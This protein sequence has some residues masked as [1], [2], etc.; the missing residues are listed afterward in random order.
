MITSFARTLILYFCI[1]FC[2]RIMG[3]R[4]LGEL[5][6]SEL[7]TSILISDLAAVPM[8][9][10]G[11]PLLQGVVPILTLFS[12][13]MLISAVSAR[14]IRFRSFF[15]GRTSVL[16]RNGQIDQQELARQRINVT[17]LLEELRLKDVFDLREVKYA[18]LET[19]GVLSIQLDPAERAATAR[20]LR[21]DT[22]AEPVLY[23]VLIAQG[24]VLTANL[25]G[26]GRD[27]VWLQKQLR[28]RGLERA[29]QVYL[30]LTDDRGG[31]MLVPRSDLC[32][33]EAVNP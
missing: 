19:N 18:C 5:Q 26:C 4:Q 29:G 20:Q 9:D 6:P 3:K 2:L 22:S 28:A 23:T 24:R 1:I 8:Q 17:E 10:L 7:V 27:E 31:V 14:S 25:R 11:I 30:M 12:V 15:C 13:E 21:V 16:I 32:P 33:G